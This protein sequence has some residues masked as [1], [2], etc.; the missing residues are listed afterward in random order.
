VRGGVGFL[1]ALEIESGI[2]DQNP[3]APIALAML[4]R[5]QGVLARPLGRGVAVSPPLTATEEH[6]EMIGDAL[7]TGVEALEST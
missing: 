6:I 3:G 2:L 5:E 4:M 7:V 1:A